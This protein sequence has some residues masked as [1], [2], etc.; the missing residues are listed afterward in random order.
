MRLAL[1][2]VLLADV[3]AAAGEGDRRALESGCLDIVGGDASYDAAAGLVKVRVDLAADSCKTVDYALRAYDPS[4]TLG[5]VSVRG[6]GQ[7]PFVVL[8]AVVPGRPADSLVAIEVTTARRGTIVDVAPDPQV[9]DATTDQ[10]QDGI[11]DNAQVLHGATPSA[12][13]ALH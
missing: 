11:Q 4:G 2:L 5:A 13:P 10:N 7:Q 3:P 1:A 12:V 9:P 6:D 8:T